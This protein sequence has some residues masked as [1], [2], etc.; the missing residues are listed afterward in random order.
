MIRAQYSEDR[1]FT[2]RN[3]LACVKRLLPFLAALVLL[4]ACKKDD[5]CPDE[6]AGGSGGCG[7]IT[8]FSMVDVNGA[9]M[10]PPDTTDWRT[11]DNWCPWAEALF[12]DLP[13]VTWVETPLPE[14]AIAG[15]PNPC[16]SQFAMWLGND[17]TS[18]VD[19]R[20][21][22]HTSQLV[23]SHDSI[24][25]NHIGIQADS[26]GVANGELFRVYYRIVHPDGTAH[27]GHGDM[28]KVE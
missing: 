4:A 17:T 1:K 11:T 6:P 16:S 26:L 24:T 2:R 5:D 23:Y 13:A 7:T 8:G 22:S 12:A 9:P 19:L 14:P 28:K 15:Y 27:R 20:I 18:H 10:M 25:S 21:I 3:I